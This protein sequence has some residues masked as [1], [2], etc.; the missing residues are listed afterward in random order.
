MSKYWAKI[1]SLIVTVLVFFSLPILGLPALAQPVTTPIKPGCEKQYIDI[2]K[3]GTAPFQNPE[4]IVSE[5]GALTTTLE[6]KYGQNKIAGCDTYLRSYNGKLVGPTLRVRSGDT[7][8]INLIN[9]LPP[10]LNP[11]ETENENKPH[12]F[13]I[14]NFHTHGLHVSPN[15]KSDNVLRLMSPRKNVSDSV[16]AYP[17][18]INLPNVHPGGTD[19][20]HSH[21][22]GATALQVS[23][24]MAG[25]LIVEGGLD[26][27]P[28]I[29][30][31]KEK[32]FVF[33]QIVYNEQGELERYDDFMP[34]KWQQS[35]R[36]ITIN[37]QIFP[38]IEMQPGEVQHWRL[39]HAGIRESINLQLHH[40]NDNHIIKLHEIAVDG[41]PLGHIDDWNEIEL[42]PGYRSDILV[43]SDLLPPGLQSQEYFLEDVSSQPK[44]SLQG[45]GEKGRILAKVIVKG[46][47]LDMSLPDVA[48]LAQVKQQEVPPDIEKEEITGSQKVVFSVSCVPKD[49]QKPTKVNFEINGTE[50]TGNV[51]RNLMLKHAEEWTLETDEPIKSGI[52]A[53]PFHIHVNPFQ[54]TRF[55]PNHESETI[56]RDTLLVKATKPEIIR[57]RY[58][59]FTGKFV[60][61]C[62]ILDHEDQGMM[63]LVQLLDEPETL[64]NLLS[65]E[66]K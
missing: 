14:T 38:V 36:R 21:L 50:F 19:W 10:E 15:D 33:Q 5:N 7:I 1:L 2:W 31:A 63:E 52:P 58:E 28:E 44:D 55:D 54:Y 51:S 59:D 39:I 45:R 27:L 3:Y 62:H 49:C 60:L 65:E 56:W 4:E 22:H 20:Y 8:H 9:N 46:S 23:S 13:N 47:P 30:Q 34:G 11:A 6:V 12:A 57:T 32:V 29:E 25:A 16:P 41:I 48:K 61:H 53:H 35:E 17:I 64:T 40:A 37:G 26:R 18:E 24:G 66:T 43:K 42:E